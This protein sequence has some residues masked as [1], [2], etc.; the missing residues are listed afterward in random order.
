MICL[1]NNTG[2]HALCSCEPGHANKRTMYYE[3]IMIQTSFEPALTSCI[4]LL[5][6]SNY[7]TMMCANS[8]N[9]DEAVGMHRPVSAYTVRLIHLCIWID[10]T[11]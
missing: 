3:E 6:M 1:I 8:E 4:S 9:F 11:D 2:G 7:L 5:W 10:V